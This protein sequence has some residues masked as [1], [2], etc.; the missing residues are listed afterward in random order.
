MTG[1]RPTA[2][3]PARLASPPATKT[4]RE[5]HGIRRHP[6]RLWNFHPSIVQFDQESSELSNTPIRRPKHSTTHI[7]DE[8]ALA[9][10]SPAVGPSRSSP[11]R[12]A[13]FG[14]RSWK[15]SCGRN[16]AR[17]SPVVP[18]LLAAN[19]QEL[20]E[21][22]LGATTSGEAA[23]A[24][25]RTIWDASQWRCAANCPKGR[26]PT[27]GTPHRHSTAHI[28]AATASGRW[29]LPFHT[30]NAHLHPVR[31]ARA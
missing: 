30:P 4:H 26:G 5:D 10:S 1:S 19:D 22:I 20:V 13:N 11:T 9:R 3:S 7:A 31:E 29:P 23:A 2:S 15:T 21:A 8:V 6:L 27:F 18:L 24:E 16:F 14:S 12:L 25:G 28:L 17:C